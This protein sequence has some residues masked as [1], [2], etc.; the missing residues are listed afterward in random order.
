MRNNFTNTLTDFPDFAVV[1]AD[2]GKTM[3][4]IIIS[5]FIMQN[6]KHRFYLSL[7]NISVFFK[8]KQNN[9]FVFIKVNFKFIILISRCVYT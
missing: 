6:M 1:F 4:M 8:L 3:K 9:E 5:K 7:F 2:N